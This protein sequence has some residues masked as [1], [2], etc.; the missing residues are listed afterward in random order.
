MLS[1]IIP[2]RNRADL[3]ASALNS[4]TR[5]ALPIDKYEVL[6]IDNGSTDQT[7]AVARESSGRLGNIRYFYEPEPGLHAGRHRGMLE[8]QGEV[9]VFA[10]DDIEALPSWL[11]SIQEAFSD[12]DVAM[13]GGNNLPMFLEPPPAWLRHLWERSA[14]RH[15]RLLS[16][17]SILELYGENPKF[18]PYLVWGCNFAICKNVLLAA[19]GF[20]PDGMPKELIRFRGDG[21]THVSRYVSESGRKCVFHPGASVYHK[22]TPERMTLQYFRQRGFSQG[23]SD[24]YTALRNQNEQRAALARG[25]MRRIVGWGWRKLRN[26]SLIDPGALRALYS[27]KL[28]HREGYAYHQQMYR[29]DAEVRAWV[30]KP[31]Y[32]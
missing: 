6:V 23:V 21:E 28:G 18:S 24:S 10:D 20:H 16:T 13:V 22:V 4:L 30:H 14:M 8:A 31:H 7:A 15:G 17:L 1:V 32:F 25:V 9:L 5:Q 19:G 2:T 27:L 11:A 12:S 26:L 29:E 3:L